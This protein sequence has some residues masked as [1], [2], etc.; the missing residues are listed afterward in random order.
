MESLLAQLISDAFEE[1]A[2]A[3]FDILGAYVPT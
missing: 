3:M 1:H 2:M